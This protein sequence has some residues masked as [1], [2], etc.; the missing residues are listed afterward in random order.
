MAYYLPL[1]GI[2]KSHVSGVAR[3]RPESLVVVEINH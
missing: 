1:R 2:V 3:Y